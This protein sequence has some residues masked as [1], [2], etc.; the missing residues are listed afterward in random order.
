MAVFQSK[1]RELSFYVD[2]ENYSFSSG[3]ISTN[4][5]KVIAVLEKMTDVKRVNQPGV[6][7]VG[8]ETEEK[9]KPAPRA[10]KSANTSGK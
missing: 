9:P 8:A 3:T 7:D 2:G 4:D 1:Y 10:R 5:A 6:I